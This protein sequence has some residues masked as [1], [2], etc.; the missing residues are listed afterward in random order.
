MDPDADRLAAVRRRPGSW[1]RTWIRGWVRWT[2]SVDDG[3]DGADAILF[4]LRIGG[5]A[6]RQ[7]DETWPLDCGCVGQETTGA[8]GLAK[9][10]RTV[11]IE[12][13]LAVRR[14]SDRANDIGMAAQRAEHLPGVHVPQPDTAIG[15]AGQDGFAIGRHHDR[16]QAGLAKFGFGRPIMRVRSR[17]APHADQLR[18]FRGGELRQRSGSVSSAR[19]AATTRQTTSGATRIVTLMTHLGGG[20]V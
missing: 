17:K 3:A 16:K 20:I 12:H 11:P 2:A 19:A 5:Q 13:P 7:R 4:Q 1:P 14:E 9:A 15:A 18:Q 8:G 6:A 10:L